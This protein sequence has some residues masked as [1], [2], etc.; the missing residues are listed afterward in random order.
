MLCP[1]LD[2]PVQERH[3]DTLA[4]GH[5]DEEASDIRKKAKGA[6]TVQPGQGLEE[7]SQCI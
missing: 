2:F 3:A 6:G 7:F 4:K 5:E 1:E